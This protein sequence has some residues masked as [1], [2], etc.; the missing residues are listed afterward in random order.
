VLA[1]QL[2]F[3][4]QPTADERRLVGEYT[5]KNG[6]ANACR[7]ILNSNEFLFVD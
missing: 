7:V 2:A 6:L 5:A 3:G 4:R 1:Y